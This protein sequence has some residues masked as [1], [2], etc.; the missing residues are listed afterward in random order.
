MSALASQCERYVICGIELTWPLLTKPYLAASL[1][2]LSFPPCT[3]TAH[4]LLVRLKAQALS[5][6]NAVTS[7][8]SVTRPSTRRES[9]IESRLW[10]RNYHLNI[11]GVWV[12]MQYGFSNLRVELQFFDCISWS[13]NFNTAVR[14]PCLVFVVTNHQLLGGDCYGILRYFPLL[15]VKVRFRVGIRN[16]RCSS[17]LWQEMISSDFGG[18][19][20]E[21]RQN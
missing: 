2:A 8:P 5:K 20:T 21:T 1:S 18:V 13:K 9:I 3:S 4:P 15:S 17:L 7:N 19:V 14:Y 10:L 16:S 12:W 11:Y 6:T